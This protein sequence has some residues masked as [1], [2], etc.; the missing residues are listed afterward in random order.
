MIVGSSENDF[1]R[2]IYYGTKEATVVGV[3]M[4]SV[5]EQLASADRAD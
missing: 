2:D 1:D 3:D 5:A 4:D